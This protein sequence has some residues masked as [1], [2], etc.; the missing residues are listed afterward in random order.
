MGEA[1]IRDKAADTWLN[2]KV[3]MDFTKSEEAYENIIEA[4]LTA[5][6]DAGRDEAIEAA[7]ITVGMYSSKIATAAAIRRLKKGQGKGWG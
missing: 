2:L 6:H 1:A 4:A 7:A 5:A 3:A